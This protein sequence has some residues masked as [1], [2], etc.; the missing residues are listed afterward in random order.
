MG[1]SFGSGSTLASPF[2]AAVHPPVFAS[3][4]FNAA[5]GASAAARPA[6]TRTSRGPKL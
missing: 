1:N 4:D 5:R 6:V 3:R 2:R